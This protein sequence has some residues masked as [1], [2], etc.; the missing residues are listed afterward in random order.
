MQPPAA[1]GSW[2]GQTCSSQQDWRALCRATLIEFRN[3][4]TSFVCCPTAA[5]PG[6]VHT[7]TPRGIV[8]LIPWPALPHTASLLQDGGDPAVQISPRDK[9]FTLDAEASTSGREATLVAQTDL[10]CA[11]SPACWVQKLQDRR[12]G[13]Q[14]TCHQ[15]ASSCAYTRCR[16][17]EG[18]LP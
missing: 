6:H 17:R 10:R 3:G 1:S 11:A 15:P 13:L 8:H 9:L 16:S 12:A 2:T 14:L 4:K 5:L 7:T 18:S